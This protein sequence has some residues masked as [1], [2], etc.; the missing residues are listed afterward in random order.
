MFRKLIG[1]CKGTNICTYTNYTYLTFYR[2]LPLLVRW[3][4]C[5]F[6]EE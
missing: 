1:I 6:G 3:L 2:L 5:Q 4:Y